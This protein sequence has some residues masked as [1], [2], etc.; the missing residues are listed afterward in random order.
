MVPFTDCTRTLG[1]PSGQWNANWFANRQCFSQALNFPNSLPKRIRECQVVDELTMPGNSLQLKEPVHRH[2]WRNPEA[3][4]VRFR[5]QMI[6]TK[7]AANRRNN[8][9]IDH[10]GI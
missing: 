8:R 4:A 6:V 1:I 3:A 9:R 2:Q 5:R 10:A 7:F